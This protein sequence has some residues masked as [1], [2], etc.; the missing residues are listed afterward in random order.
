VGN[1]ACRLSISNIR[2]QLMYKTVHIGIAAVAMIV[3]LSNAAQAE[4]APSAGTAPAPA[5]A[6][7]AAP[8]PAAAA[9]A[10]AVAPAPAPAP[11]A[12]PAPTAST[13]ATDAPADAAAKPIKTKT[14]RKKTTRDREINR[15][16]ESGT[17]PS[18]YRNS[19]PKEYQQYIP[20]DRR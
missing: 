3:A 13:P 15:S 16:I 12:T 2:E 18:R 17:V 9:P 6:T 19:V 8:A 10:P 20:F 14:A 1:D 7:P 4:D 11:A 5:A